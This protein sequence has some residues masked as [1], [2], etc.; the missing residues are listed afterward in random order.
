MTRIEGLTIIQ[1]HFVDTSNY[2]EL[3]SKVPFDR[4]KELVMTYCPAGTGR[5][6]PKPC[7]TWLAEK[8][9]QIA[10]GKD[11]ISNIELASILEEAKKEE[12]IPS[13]QSVKDGLKREVKKNGEG[14]EVVRSDNRQGWHLIN[15]TLIPYK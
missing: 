6:N 8:I 12:G 9:K 14:V 4:L 2:A 3:K 1:D 13:F 11:Y 10:E 5:G 7:N 15:W